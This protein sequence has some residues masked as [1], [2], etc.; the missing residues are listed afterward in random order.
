MKFLVTPQATLN[1]LGNCSCTSNYGTV[2]NN[3][4][5]KCTANCS[6]LQVCVTPT[7]A[8]MSPTGI[9]TLE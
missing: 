9:G 5:S 3:E 4:C 6:T 1:P 8:K 7:G 2:T